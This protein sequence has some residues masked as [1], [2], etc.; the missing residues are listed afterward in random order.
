[1]EKYIAVIMTIWLA[2]QVIRVIQNAMQLSRYGEGYE[3]SD[4]H[5]FKRV[6]YKLEDYLDRT[7]EYFDRLE[8]DNLERVEADKE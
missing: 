4:K 6:L 1:M 8:D 3:P 5:L 2:T 7:E